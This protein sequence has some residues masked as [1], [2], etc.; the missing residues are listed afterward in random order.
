MFRVLE[1][2]AIP[3]LDDEALGAMSLKELTSQASL[4]QGEEF[5]YRDRVGINRTLHFSLDK[6][7]TL[8]LI[9]LSASSNPIAALVQGLRPESNPHLS[10]SRP[11]LP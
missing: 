2:I 1:A 8:A 11:R 10:Q 5:P 6:T 9:A 4:L 7:I 3:E